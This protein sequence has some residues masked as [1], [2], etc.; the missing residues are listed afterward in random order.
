MFANAKLRIIGI[1][2]GLGFVPVHISSSHAQIAADPLVKFGMEI[3][4]TSLGVSITELDNSRPV[5]RKFREGDIL[6]SYTVIVEGKPQLNKI[7]NAD[8]VDDLKALIRDGQK[9]SVTVLRPIGGEQSNYQS[10]ELEIDALDLMRPSVVALAPQTYTKS[11]ST[12]AG[13]VPVPAEGEASG[14]IVKVHYATD[15]RLEASGQYSGERDL[16]PQP[17][18]YGICEVSIPPNHRRGQLESP[19]MWDWYPAEP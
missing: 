5:A 11:Y 18:K 3:A 6:V 4:E 10:I 9:V 8:S 17:I 2:L 14:M 16:T 19:T 15:R 13:D 12:T 1:L 7:L